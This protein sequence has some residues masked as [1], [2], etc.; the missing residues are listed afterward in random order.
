M[1]IE[2]EAPLRR[3]TTLSGYGLQANESGDIATV[4]AADR[5]ASLGAM[6]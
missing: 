2:E 5:P 1:I 6:A 4:A 3:R